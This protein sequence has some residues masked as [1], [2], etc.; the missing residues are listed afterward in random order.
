MSRTKIGALAALVLAVVPAAH[1]SAF[2]LGPPDARDANAVA[3]QR[4]ADAAVPRSPDAADLNR[5]ARLH[6]S[7][8]AVVTVPAPAAA[9]AADGFDLGD[10]GIGAGAAVMLAGLAAGA[11]VAARRRVP[12]PS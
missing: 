5:Y 1:A 3:Q 7:R 8:P 11:A 4:I 9:K 12:Q 6:E 2:T 10:A